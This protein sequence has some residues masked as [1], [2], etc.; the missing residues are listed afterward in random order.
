MY[1][2][3]GKDVSIKLVSSCP[4]ITILQGSKEIGQSDSGE[5]HL[6]SRSSWSTSSEDDGYKY[7]NPNAGFEMKI[8]ADADKTKEYSFTVQ[9]FEGSSLKAEE[10]YTFTLE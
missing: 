4:E 9:V 10:T 5:Y 3:R 7:M 1:Y 2:G 6:A 8:A